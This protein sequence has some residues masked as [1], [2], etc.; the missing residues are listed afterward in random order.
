MIIRYILFLS[1]LVL[2]SSLVYSQG[3]TPDLDPNKLTFCHVTINSDDEKKVF[4]KEL[5]KY[6]GEDQFQ[7]IEL[8]KM[9]D[10]H[11][12]F[13]NSCESKIKCD[14][15][16][17]SGHFGGSFFGS[18]GLSISSDDLESATCSQTCEGILSNPIEVYLWGCNTL[19]GKKK[20]NRTPEEYRQVLIDDGY[21]Y[22]EAERI[23]TLRYSPIGTSFRDQM[24]RTFR[25]VPHLYGFKSVGPAGNSVKRMLENYLDKKK[26][27]AGY[28]AA[29]RSKQLVQY[30]DQLNGKLEDPLNQ[31]KGNQEIYEALKTTYFTQVVSQ[32]PKCG[33]DL[34][35]ELGDAERIN[36]S[37][38][39]SQLSN[40][41]RL[42]VT[43]DAFSG[44]DP[45]KFIP[46]INDFIAKLDFKQL[47][48]EEKK[49]LE[50]IKKN[51]TA[52]INIID[53]LGLLKPLPLTYLKVVSLSG[54]L[55]WLNGIELRDRYRESILPMLRA[56]FTNENKDLVCSMQIDSDIL[57]FDDVDPEIF[58]D[59]YGLEMIGCLKPKDKRIESK[60]FE[61]LRKSND[62]GKYIRTLG[63]LEI[64]NED[65]QLYL[66][67]ILLRD[68]N[69]SEAKQHVLVAFGRIKPTNEKI[70]LII[71]ESLIDQDKWVRATAVDTLKIIKATNEKVHFLI[72]QTLKDK[73]VHIRHSAA[74]F[75]VDIKTN[76]EKIHFLLAEALR[77]KDANVRQNA[78]LALTK[79][80]P[81]NENIHLLLAE[82][83]KDEDRYVRQSV[84]STLGAL[85]PTNGKVHLLIAEALKDEN[86]NVRQY[87]ASAL[88]QIKPTNEKIHLLLAEAINDK[89]SNVA[90]TAVH[91]LSQVK[92][93]SEKVHLLLARAFGH[94]NENIRWNVRDALETIEVK[95]KGVE[96]ELL[97]AYQK[98]SDGVKEDL[99]QYFYKQKT[100]SNEV[101]A[102]SIKILEKDDDANKPMATL[103]LAKN[104]IKDEKVLLKIID[105]V[106]DSEAYV[107]FASNLAFATL[108]SS[109]LEIK[110]SLDKSLSSKDLYLKNSAAIAILKKEP[111]NTKAREALIE[112][113][114]NVDVDFDM[115]GAIL[116]ALAEVGL[117]DEAVLIE[118]IK[119]IFATRGEEDEWQHPYYLTM[120]SKIKPCS[121]KILELLKDSVA[122]FERSWEC[123]E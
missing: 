78:A 103:I 106:N 112:D 94:E 52:K 67:G 73:D 29:E 47:S 62:N 8:T 34:L 46:G 6:G 19:A 85:K 41:E 24:Q 63:H 116:F 13:Q 74:N 37:L 96:E 98:G 9:G 92:P 36:C 53:S 27:F 44:D 83:L 7:F 70:H 16:S 61:L 87:A 40:V 3:Y 109:H 22:E 33:G 81:G 2:N 32:T 89:D 121:P 56:P 111:Q 110:T 115:K 105:G 18:S 48:A 79:I 35:S 119:P 97:N 101:I 72:A 113:I 64:A 114:K 39:N 31:F 15:L 14:V 26:D 55:G 59:Y 12:W 5:K 4:E 117:N 84:I 100:V 57:S 68:E 51:K 11:D 90:E 77:D 49:L 45:L 20:D 10:S 108:D 58:N 71:A 21:T 102:E 23:A 118:L 120:F 75:F 50:K 38:R 88:S 43:N 28:L 93:T 91:A 69:P 66:S 1:F 42:E 25:G 122:S 76:N 82:A 107:R 17:I 54:K 99:F 123:P 30:L 65:I 60:I 95:S 80:K 86:L 104:N